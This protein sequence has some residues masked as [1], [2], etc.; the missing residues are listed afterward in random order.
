M[1]KLCLSL[2]TKRA[3]LLYGASPS[4]KSYV[5]SKVAEMHGKRCRTV[6]LNHESTSEAF[7]GRCTLSNKEN[8]PIGFR[9]GPLI[10]AI[11]NGEWIVIE[12]I[13]L[14]SSDVMEA[15]NS[16]CEENPILNVIKGNEE[17]TYVSSKPQE[18]QKRI[19]HDFRLFFTISDTKLKHFTGPFLS[20][21]VILFCDSIANAQSVQEICY[22]TESSVD[23]LYFGDLEAE[24]FRR[25][26]RVIGSREKDAF[27]IEFEREPAKHDLI[28][29]NKI[30]NSIEHDLEELSD[31]L[32]EGKKD[33]KKA[34]DLMVRLAKSSPRSF[35]TE[36]VS[37]RL[38]NIKKYF[39]QNFVGFIMNAIDMIL[40]RNDL[41]NSP[42]IKQDDENT[43]ILSRW[44]VL[45]SIDPAFEKGCSVKQLTE[46]RSISLA[47][48]FNL[49]TA[50]V[51][52]LILMY[53]ILNRTSQFLESILNEY[54]KSL[55]ES[56]F[57]PMNML[58]K[59]ES[60][61]LLA[62]NLQSVKFIYE[63]LSLEKKPERIT[64]NDYNDILSQEKE[65]GAI[66][67]S[68][69]ESVMNCYG[70]KEMKQRITDYISDV[71]MEY[72]AMCQNDNS[73]ESQRV[74]FEAAKHAGSQYGKFGD[75]LDEVFKGRMD[76]SMFKALR[77]NEEDSRYS[78]WKYESEY[79]RLLV[80]ASHLIYKLNT[81]NC[82]AIILNEYVDVLDCFK[83][84][85]RCILMH[86]TEFDA[87][88]NHSIVLLNWLLMREMRDMKWEKNVC[89]YAQYPFQMTS[90]VTKE[91][92]ED[93]IDALIVHQWYEYYVEGVSTRTE[94]EKKNIE[95]KGLLMEEYS[96]ETISSIPL[97]SP[98]ILK[99][100]DTTVGLEE[101]SYSQ[102]AMVES[103]W[104]EFEYSEV[105]EGVDIPAQ[106]MMMELDI[107]SPTCSNEDKLGIV[108]RKEC[109][110]SIDEKLEIVCHRKR[111]IV[112]EVVIEY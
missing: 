36:V 42:L 2:K 83:L 90:S 64:T 54:V 44:C 79:G 91:Q 65:F 24:S 23:P 32:E 35:D 105:G 112:G 61:E 72:M 93:A 50:N 111:T 94:R 7:I 56:G 98:G 104:R 29:K 25:C 110:L 49:D 85:I 69:P 12:D 1:F 73:V 103:T 70:L 10:E 40:W 58:E 38:R 52:Q 100:I 55:F 62:K 89:G 3:M 96:E 101:Y 99:A 88:K 51:Y 46:N 108:W 109:M 87:V 97:A 76:G 11:E 8:E 80:K 34:I 39:D 63:N 74:N 15:L 16:L 26:C 18:G 92:Y 6:Y 9:D 4:G 66:C 45:T 20:R 28:A 13:H 47:D 60:I 106:V 31:Q 41:I 59:G 37:Q 84:Q 27:K 22:I 57:D 68:L 17:V 82:P 33:V 107:I 75:V 43:T 21:C 53:Y 30:H 78:I 95:L 5:V 102:I 81:F 19:R 67:Q 77:M 48:A 71:K 86:F 14:A